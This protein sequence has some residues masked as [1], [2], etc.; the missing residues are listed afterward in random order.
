MSTNKF[1]T[2]ALRVTRLVILF[3]MPRPSFSLPDWPSRNK[4][5]ERTELE[6]DLEIETVKKTGRDLDVEKHKEKLGVRD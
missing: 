2:C 1:K 3:V 4:T 6:S 5:L